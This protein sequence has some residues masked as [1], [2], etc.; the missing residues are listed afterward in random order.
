MRFSR[1]WGRGGEEIFFLYRSRSATVEQ[2]GRVYARIYTAWQRV[3]CRREDNGGGPVE[4]NMPNCHACT[5][6]H[7]A[8]PPTQSPRVGADREKPF[9]LSP[10]EPFSSH[11]YF[12]VPFN[13]TVT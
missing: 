7:T 2:T 4:G 11:G 12:T 9:A 1:I 6:V 10:S 3:A 8:P 13:V 5:R